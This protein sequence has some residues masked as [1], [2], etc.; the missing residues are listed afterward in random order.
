MN[1]PFA[2]RQRDNCAPVAKPMGK[3]LND[4]KNKKVWHTQAN[5]H[6]DRDEVMKSTKESMEPGLYKTNYMGEC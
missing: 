2:K 3:I 6:Y 5:I 1:S 4:L